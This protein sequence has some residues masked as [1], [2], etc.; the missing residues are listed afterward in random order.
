MQCK[1]SDNTDFNIQHN[2]FVDKSS[3]N[4][5]I[6]Y[7]NITYLIPYDDSLTVSIIHL[8]KKT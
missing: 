8:N 5:T 6:L 4:L 1:P 7:G 2:L 3:G